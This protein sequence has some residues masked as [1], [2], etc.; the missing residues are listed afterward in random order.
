MTRDVAEKTT[1]LTQNAAKRKKEE[2][3]LE[4]ENKEIVQKQ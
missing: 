4:R 1:T 2:Q 3:N